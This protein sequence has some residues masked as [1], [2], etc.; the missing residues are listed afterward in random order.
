MLL[1]EEFIKS[2]IKSVEYF[3]PKGTLTI[4]V[5]T[6]DNGFSVTGESACINPANFNK[7]IGQAIAYKKA[8]DKLWEPMGYFIVER[9]FLKEQ[10]SN[11]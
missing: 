1:T 6:L 2:R 10:S 7:E 4:A 8:F 9:E 3:N 5:I 11:T